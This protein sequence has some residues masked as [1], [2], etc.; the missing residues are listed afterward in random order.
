[1]KERIDGNTLRKVR[2]M[3]KAGTEAKVFDEECSGLAIRTYKSGKA[4]WCILTRDWKF[5]LGDLSLF[6]GDRV[7]ALREA[8]ATARRMKADG[9]NPEAFLKSF[10]G[11]ADVQRASHDAATSSGDMETW[12]QARDRYLEAI[13]EDNARDTHRSYRSAIG[14]VPGSPLEKD[15]EPVHGKPIASVTRDDLIAVRDNIHKRGKNAGPGALIRQANF[16]LAVIKAFMKWQMG[17]GGNPLASNPAVEITAVKKTAGRGGKDFKGIVGV[18]AAHRAM[19]QRELGLVIRGLEDYTNVPARTA[20]L[21][22]LMTGQRRMTICEARKAAFEDHPEYGMTWTLEDKTRSW[23]IL[24][25]PP[26]AEAAVRAAMSLTR[27]D[28]P[29]LFPQQRERQAGQGRDGHMNERTM[30]EVLEEMRAPGGILHGLPFNVSTH[31][32]RKAFVSRMSGSMHKYRIGDQQL[33]EKHIEMITHLDE[34]REGTASQVYDLNPH[35]GIKWAI[36]S[37][38]EQWVLEGYSQVCAEAQ[39]AA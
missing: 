27:S 21:L 26:T 6:G 12:E 36:L 16:S 29:Y 14:A 18:S 9:K 39:K 15:F 28:N 34:G 38:W 20:T 7:D 35:L 11:G 30:S 1:M 32:L 17:R 23:R 25:L 8:V 13:L 4:T 37:E 31:K 5:T 2:N 22:Q 33:T 10:V 3:M 24:P 19:N